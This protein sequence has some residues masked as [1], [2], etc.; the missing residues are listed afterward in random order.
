MREFLRLSPTNKT[1]LWIMALASMISVIVYLGASSLNYGI[2]FPLDDSWIHLTYARNLVE[3]GE[4]AFHPG[5][6]SAG[7][8]SPLW[9]GLLSIGFLLNLAP[10]FWTFMLGALLLWGMGIMAEEIVR[11]SLPEYKSKFP[12]V[13]LFL[14]TEWHLVWSAVSGMETILHALLLTIILGLIMKGSHRF[15][16][17]GVLAGLSIWVRPD[18]LTLL[19]P[20]IVY[21][22]INKDIEKKR[23]HKIIHFLI[24][25]FSLFI[26]YLLFN[27][28]LAGSPMP[29]T[30]Y[31]KQAEYSLWQARPFTS[32]LLDL[33]LQLLTG[34]GLA[35]IPATIGW[36][37][38]SLRK[39]DWGTL[40]GMLWFVGYL[41]LYVQ[42]LPVYQHGRYIIPA[43]PVFF[44]WGLKGLVVFQKSEIFR[45][46]QWA[47]VTGWNIL[48]GTLCIAFWFLGAKTFAKDVSIIESEMVASAQWIAENIPPKDIIAA[49][50]IGALGYF[51]RHELID[52]AGLVSPEVIPFI[53]DEEKLADFLDR[54]QAKYLI[55]FPEFY[56][57]LISQAELI[58]STDGVG[59]EMGGG[60]MGV[61]RWR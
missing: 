30:F 5:K 33:V 13:G 34:P 31:A 8:T 43:M 12:W 16:T 37:V 20:V 46:Y 60:N 18:G 57:I 3:F 47:A 35:L 32:R 21:A 14:I 25:F 38:I 48:V 44:I 45:K 51:D 15:I 55:A 50:D 36:F 27:L 9:T 42:R 22:L 11:Y 58:Y 28:L 61:Y 52:L 10:Y 53:R 6:P 17:M 49:H 19:G 41:Y 29:N 26:P 24:G 56:P 23:W 1:N 59:P 7:S 2:G 54:N 4:W 40:V 39:R